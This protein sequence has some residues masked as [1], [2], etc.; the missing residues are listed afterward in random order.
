VTDVT[1]EQGQDGTEL[2]AVDEQLL[3][4]FTERARTGGTEPHWRGR[5]A[6]QADQDDGEGPREGELDDHLGHLNLLYRYITQGRAEAD[7]PHLSP[8]HVTRLLLTRPQSLSDHQR[9][10]LS[11][12]AAACPEMTSLAG[13][14]RS[15]TAL[16]KPARERARLQAW[17]EAARARDP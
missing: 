13:L 10:P 2:T 6:G 12:L 11:K 7:R 3:R 15:F 4:E 8:K 5:A 14:V 17:S 16:L 9:S 1:N